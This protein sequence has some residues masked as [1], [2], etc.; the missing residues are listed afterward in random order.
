MK[1]IFKIIYFIF[2]SP[3]FIFVLAKV[4]FIDFLIYNLIKIL[5]PFYRLQKKL[6]FNLL[7]SYN[8]KK[9]NKI[10]F[11]INNKKY[12]NF[13]GKK[14]IEKLIV[15]KKSLKNL[16]SKI[17]IYKNVIL[18]E[19]DS[20]GFFVSDDFKINGLVNI[21]KKK[22]IPRTRSK[23]QLIANINGI[24]IKKTFL[25]I[26][27][28]KRFLYELLVFDKLRKVKINI[29]K[30]IHTNLKNL[31]LTMEFI[32][33]DLETNFFK[34]GI[35]LNS[36]E[37][38]KKFKRGFS[39]YKQRQ[40]EYI[41][42]GRKAIKS[43]DKKL[44]NSI[45]DQFKKL[46]QNGIRIYDVKYGNIAI[47]HS[48][49]KP[50]F[51]DFDSADIFNPKSLFF[52]IERDRDTNKF[53]TMFNTSLLTYD[54]LKKKINN[55]DFP[56]SDI[57]YSSF[58]IGSGLKIGRLWDI[59]VGFGRWHFNVK[60]FIKLKSSTKIL[61][62]GTNNASLELL[63]L[64]SGARTVIGYEKNINYIKQGYF[65][66]NA[67]NW[68]NNQNYNLKY[69]NKDISEFNKNKKT[70]DVV[71]ALCSIYYLSEK[72]I[73]TLIKHFKLRTKTIYLQCNHSKNIGRSK[74]KEYEKASLNFT[75]KILLKNKL[76][77]IQ[78]KAP[79]SYSRPM[80]KVINNL[81]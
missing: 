5:S 44:V 33:P 47:H 67:M 20:N 29:P 57:L 48:T 70:Q 11:D 6:I 41:A 34:K 39:T 78:I 52:L 69:I 40:D 50:Y 81:N 23:L 43:Y 22:K 36:R 8:F 66:L 68:Y 7:L 74:K 73:N 45:S 80:I 35:F 28:K 75:K 37:I 27:A 59:S 25:G 15:N 46:H 65:L 17:K 61:S 16:F 56:G 55:S 3:K 30:I 54:L 76:S 60:N 12:I 19:I 18:G 24:F 42:R 49:G 1:N 79:L 58:Y 77:N 72:K 53:N 62:L 2:Y 14:N 32:G 31:S 13:N 10:I 63:M 38:N 26:D 71:V 9:S 64:K 21:N 51:F 4:Y